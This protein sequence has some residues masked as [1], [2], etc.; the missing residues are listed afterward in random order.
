MAIELEKIKAWDGQS[1]TGS[2]AR[3]VIDTN[4]EKIKTELETVDTKLEETDEK[5]VQ[6]A[7]DTTL[8]RVDFEQGSFNTNSG[9]EVPST[10]RI[11]SVYLNYK[12]YSE[13]TIPDNNNYTFLSV[14]LFDANKQYIGSR[15]DF[16]VHDNGKKMILPALG[17]VEYFRFT[18]QKNGEAITPEEA[19]NIG[20]RLLGLK[21]YSEEPY[22]L[23]RLSLTSGVEADST[24]RI[25]S[26]YIKYDDVYAIDI[27]DGY[28]FFIALF[29]RNRQFIENRYLWSRTRVDLPYIENVEYFRISIRNANNPSANIRTNEDTGLRFF[30]SKYGMRQYDRIAV[31]AKRF[32]VLRESDLVNTVET[33]NYQTLDLIPVS[34]GDTIYITVN[35][36][37][38]SDINFRT[39]IVGYSDEEYG[40]PVILYSPVIESG[41]G[42]VRVLER[43]PLTIS[44][45]NINFIRFSDIAA[46]SNHVV[47]MKVERF[48][49]LREKIDKLS[50]Q[51]K[52]TPRTG[53]SI[54]YDD[55]KISVNNG[56][57]GNIVFNITGTTYI[58]GDPENGFG[59]L[60]RIRETA[61]K[62]EIF[63]FDLSDNLV[64]SY[65]V[66]YKQNQTIEIEGMIGDSFGDMGFDKYSNIAVEG[67]PDCA[68][69]IDYD[70]TRFG[71]L[72][73][74]GEW[75]S[76]LK[77][78]TEVLYTQRTRTAGTRYAA[79]LKVMKGFSA[80]QLLNQPNGR[81]ATF[82]FVNHADYQTIPRQDGIMYG[83][84][85]PSH[86]NRGVKGIIS[87]GLKGTWTVFA[88]SGGSG[89]TR[90]EGL[91]NPEYMTACLAL[92]DAGIEIIPHT[93]SYEP[94]SRAETQQYLQYYEPF[95]PR[96]WVDHMIRPTRISSGLHSEGNDPAKPNNYI[97]D[98]L[99]DIDYTWSYQD[100]PEMA[101]VEKNQLIDGRFAFPKYLLFQN[102][103]LIRPQNGEVWQYQN[104][105]ETMN[106]FITNGMDVEPF[107]QELVDKC[108]VWTEHC[109]MALYSRQDISWRNDNG[110]MVI[111]DEQDYILERVQNRVNSGEIWNPTMTEWLDYNVQLLNV[112]MKHKNSE[113][114]IINNNE[115]PINGCSFKINNYFN[116]PKLN[117]IAMNRKVVKNGIIVWCD[118]KIGESVMEL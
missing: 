92:R 3:V 73:Y 19:G 49:P 93:I 71:L 42:R 58:A 6:L 90:N 66:Q 22:Q 94:A 110:T 20:L 108:G 85:S 89:N 117:G 68:G 37:E 109:Y 64:L 88:R 35:L 86:P 70:K 59:K 52:Q 84:S 51:D 31:E 77:R 46:G 7:G 96:N 53:Y 48:I 25:S 45:D 74:Y 81:N 104:A 16:F 57:Q 83:A 36:W 34:K 55:S 75:M 107:I 72:T 69:Y 103:L 39:P 54:R 41:P 29:D 63:T 13:I 17:G 14:R 40:N 78:D 118:L 95:S 101:D 106:Y 100:T 44:D 60:S 12:V 111:T 97:M 87:R 33:T 28:E 5:I 15:S 113:I 11:R 76:H 2:D 47:E 115:N 82:T 80:V 114:E 116:T 98:L 67:S 61:Q 112:E 30:H 10:V 102:Q 38:S 27:N 23:Y 21:Y 26:R 105:W 50:E 32:V 56:N 65:E 79:K 24:T 4:F 99:E 9:A 43:Y 8:T 91:D 1:G 18:V 62:T